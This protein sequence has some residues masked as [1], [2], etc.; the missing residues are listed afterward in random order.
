MHTVNFYGNWIPPQEMDDWFEHW[1]S[2]GVKPLFT[3]EYS[4]PF[5][6][7]WSMYRGWYKG[8]REFGSAVV[9]WEFH[10]A[11]CDA[12]F[13]GDRAYRITEAEAVNLR[14][15]AEQF[16][17]GRS[18]WQRWDYPYNLGSQAFEDRLRIMAMQVEQNW[19]AFR[20][21]GLSA[22]GAPWDIGNYW[23]KTGEPTAVADALG[24]CNMPLL[25]YIGGKR[26]AFTSKDHNFLPNETV[27]KQLIVINS[28]R[29][30]V[31]GKCSW[32]LGAV[33]GSAE[34]N[35]PPGAISSAVTRPPRVTGV[36]HIQQREDTGRF[37]L[38]RRAAAF[39]PPQA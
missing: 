23:K 8:K 4:V 32:R 5:L 26:A 7:D 10:V 3:C 22:N 15:E 36:G 6:W 16:R 38:D 24:R 34:V 11:E 17:K 20:T 25:A 31:T 37:V 18:G 28:S 39:G 27:E 1:S 35:L 14:W 19:R 9:P 30:S 29:E 21:W 13:L 33:S 2:T 12:Q